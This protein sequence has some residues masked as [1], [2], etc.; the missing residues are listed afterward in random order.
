[1]PTMY[2]I[3][4][5]RQSESELG[6]GLAVFGVSRGYSYKNS[7]IVVIGKYTCSEGGAFS[8]N[9]CT[10]IPGISWTP[11]RKISF[12]PVLLRLIHPPDPYG[13]R[14]PKVRTD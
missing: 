4:K 8:W 13:L 6:R 14:L 10:G 7:D 3:R 11:S 1:M 5:G 12:P 2:R 9:S